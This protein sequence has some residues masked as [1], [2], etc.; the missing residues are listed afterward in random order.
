[1]EILNLLISLIFFGAIYGGWKLFFS[2]KKIRER[3][4]AMLSEQNRVHSTNFPTSEAELYRRVLCG[5]KI[6]LA[7]DEKN[8]KICIVQGKNCRV[9][10]FS[11]IRTWQLC[12]SEAAS[13]GLSYKEV[14]F[15]IGTSDI[16]NPALRIYM[17]SKSYAEEWESRLNILLA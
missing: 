12:W 3:I 1:M 7:F 14:H 17:A 6:Q 9:V 5:L 13:V 4:C 10:D 15:K 16:D 11:Y 8:K 2:T